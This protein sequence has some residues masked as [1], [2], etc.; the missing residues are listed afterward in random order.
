[1]IKRKRVEEEVADI[2]IYLTYICDHF[3]IDLLEA[4]DN[5]LKL[6]GKKYPVEKSHSSNKKYDEL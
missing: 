4:V 1:M 2:F 3:D 6:N 5:K